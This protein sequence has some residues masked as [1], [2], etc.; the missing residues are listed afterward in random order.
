M[1]SAIAY[2][3][4]D[5]CQQ[6]LRK[7]TILSLLWGYRSMRFLPPFVTICFAA[8]F[9]G[10]CQVWWAPIG[11]SWLK[12]DMI[13]LL[14]EANH[15]LML[16]TIYKLLVSAEASVLFNLYYSIYLCLLFQCIYVQGCMHVYSY[17]C[18]G[19]ELYTVYTYIILSKLFS[20]SSLLHLHFFLY[21]IQTL[22]LYILKWLVF[23]MKL[24]IE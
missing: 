17:K 14:S 22:Y 4:P 6:E 5:L 3:G 8:F 9:S 20:T 16:M 11:V 19:V 13:V 21:Y 10:Q 2:A 18:T 7:H 1:T 23:W 24:S 15:T 12:K